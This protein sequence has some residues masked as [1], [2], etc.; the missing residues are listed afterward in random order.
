LKAE[1]VAYALSCDPLLKEYRRLDEAI[2]Q[3]PRIKGYGEELVALKK[4]MA[5]SMGEKEK[6][7]EA[8]ARYEALLVAIQT[9]PLLANRDAL[10]EQVEESLLEVRDALK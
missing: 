7:A 2:R 1:D 8:K 3:D 9:N 6:H 4:A 10:L 5:L